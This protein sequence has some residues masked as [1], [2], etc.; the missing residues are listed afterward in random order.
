MYIYTLYNIINFD[1][2]KRY[3][4]VYISGNDAC[5]VIIY[6]IMLLRSYSQTYIIYVDL[7]R[8]YCFGICR[9]QH[10]FFSSNHNSSHY[11]PTSALLLCIQMVKLFY[12]FA[13]SFRM[14]N[15]LCSLQLSWST[16][17]LRKYI[18]IRFFGLWYGIS[19]SFLYYTYNLWF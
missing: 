7:L 15:F 3:Y 16:I 17:Y 5:K 14:Y 2:L 6:V 12:T 19:F 13:S 18:I 1:F 10:F 11:L 8:T 4:A 9:R